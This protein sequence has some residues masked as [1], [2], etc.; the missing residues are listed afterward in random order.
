MG[1]ISRV[2]CR[3]LELSDQIKKLINECRE[4]VA[5]I[6]TTPVLFAVM[7]GEQAE[8]GWIKVARLN[9]CPEV[10]APDHP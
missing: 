3:S 2:D 9:C 5:R 7:V 4:E 6:K 10:R 1:M 8:M